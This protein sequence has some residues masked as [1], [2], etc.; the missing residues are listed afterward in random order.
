MPFLLQ[1]SPARTSA[2]SETLPL[3]PLRT[4]VDQHQMVVRAAG[5]NVEA[6]ALQGLGERARIVDDVLRVDLEIG[7]KGFAE[8]HGLGGD[9]VH[10]RTALEARKHRR[11]DLLRHVLVVGEDQA[12]ARTAERLVGR[13]GHDMGMRKRRRVRATGN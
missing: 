11:V 13:R 9:D 3:K 6:G 5:D 7:A 1:V 12:A 8:G 2:F 4:E 10:Q